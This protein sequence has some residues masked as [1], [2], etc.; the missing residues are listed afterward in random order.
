MTSKYISSKFIQ[1]QIEF[2]E[3]NAIPGT[4]MSKNFGPYRC[5]LAKIIMIGITENKRNFNSDFDK[6]RQISNNRAETYLIL[7]VV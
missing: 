7:F 6:M 4:Y 3:D 2:S 1:S 5:L